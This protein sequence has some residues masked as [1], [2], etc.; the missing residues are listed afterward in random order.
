MFLFCYGFY[1]GCREAGSGTWLHAVVCMCVC[2]A[3]G[4]DTLCLLLCA[5]CRY[6]VCMLSTCFSLIVSSGCSECAHTAYADVGNGGYFAR[7]FHAHV[8]AA[9]VQHTLLPHTHTHTHTHTHAV[10]LLGA[11]FVALKNTRGGIAPRE[12]GLLVVHLPRD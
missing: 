12:Q 3:K 9:S 4:F 11:T 1:G 7:D 10:L 8:P 2:Q 6:C 5:T